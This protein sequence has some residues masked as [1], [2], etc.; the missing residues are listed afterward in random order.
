MSSNV[1][2]RRSWRPTG[3]GSF[4]AG[5]LRVARPIVGLVEGEDAATVVKSVADS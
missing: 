3:H 5:E 1:F 4:R 2:V